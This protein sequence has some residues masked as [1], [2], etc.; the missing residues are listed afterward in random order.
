MQQLA[1]VYARSLFEVAMEH[2]VLDDVHEQLGEFVDASLP[3]SPPAPRV[4]FEPAHPGWAMSSF[5]LLHGVEITEED[6]STVPA[7][8]IDELF[9]QK[10]PK[11]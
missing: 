1:D 5:E 6:P 11:A 10:P 8:L 2:D 4:P 7:E 3:A 9:N